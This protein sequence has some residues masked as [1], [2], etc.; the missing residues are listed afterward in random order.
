[1]SCR[2]GYLLTDSPA[3]SADSSSLAVS[4]SSC[5]AENRT[6]PTLAHPRRSSTISLSPSPITVSSLLELRFDLR[7]HL[8]VSPSD[9]LECFAGSASAGPPDHMPRP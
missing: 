8:D 5:K 6:P 9:P 4:S 3:P 7:C 1:M 2:L